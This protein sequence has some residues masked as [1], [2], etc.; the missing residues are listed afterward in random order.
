MKSVRCFR[1]ILSSVSLSLF[2][3]CLMADT[4]LLDVC[5]IC[6]D[7][8]AAIALINCTGNSQWI[9]KHGALVLYISNPQRHAG[10]GAYRTNNQSITHTLWIFKTTICSTITQQSKI[11][12]FCITFQHINSTFLK[13]EKIKMVNVCKLIPQWQND[14]SPEYISAEKLTNYMYS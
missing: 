7:K 8:W 10:G 11:L 12:T 9:H 13:T 6:Q 1:K 5:S 2:V 14:G 3:Q 4:S